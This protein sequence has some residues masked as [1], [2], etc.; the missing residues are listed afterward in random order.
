MARRVRGGSADPTT[1]WAQAAVRGDFVVGDLV[2]YAAERHLRDLRDAEKRGYFWRPELAQRALDFFPSVFTITDGPAAGKP[3]HLLPYQTFCV[4][5]LMG[6]VNAD[7]R[8][9][10]RNAFVETGKGQAKSPM[11]AGLGLFAMGWCGFPRAQVYSIAANKQTANVLFKDAFAMCRAQVPGYDEGETLEGLGHVLLRGEGDNVWKIEHPGSQSFFLPLAGGTAQSGP[12][13]RMVLAD[14]IHEFTVDTQIEIWRRA[15]TKVAGSAMMVMGTNTPATSQLVGTSYSNTAIAIAK[16]DVKDDTQFAFVARVDKRDHDDVFTKEECWPKALPALGITYPVQ[17][18]RE[19]VATAQIGSLERHIFPRAGARALAAID[20][21]ELL[22]L[23]ELIDGAETAR[24]V[25]QRLD[26]IFAFARPRGW[27]EDNPAA[28]IAAELAPPAAPIR[29][30]AVTIAADARGAYSAIASTSARPIVNLAAQFLALTAVRVGSLR[31]ATWDEIKTDEAGAPVWRI[32]AAHLKLSRA[33]K[34]SADHDHLVPLS[35]AAMAVLEAARDHS[36]GA[37]AK[38]FP[39]GERAIGELHHRAGLTGRH[40]PHGWRASFST[41]LNEALPEE[42]IAIDEA[43][44]H[45]V[46]GKVEGAYNRAA[47]IDRRRTL[48]DAWAAILAGEVAAPEH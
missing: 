35:P 21:A 17:N 11:M 43:L 12:R 6:W 25:R 28:L 45:Q 36:G 27:V 1:A 38:I 32:P 22:E 16:G 37:A 10:F 31:L 19:E 3:F 4:G 14:E 33:R 41:V 44:A 46:K 2:K 23:L 24:R 5:S 30:P 48:F 18:L 7:G 15:I 47:Q 29:H 26:A 13:P 42:R 9:R 39:I 20:A 40:V 8:W 34:A